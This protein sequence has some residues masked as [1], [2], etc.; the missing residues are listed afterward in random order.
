MGVNDEL[1][2]YGLAQTP[3]LSA[4]EAFLVLLAANGGQ[5]GVCATDDTGSFNENLEALAAA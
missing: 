3:D 2:T 1:G 4:T 5:D